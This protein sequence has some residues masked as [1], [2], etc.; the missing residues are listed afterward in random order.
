MNV[1]QIKN[2]TVSPQEIIPLLDHSRLLPHFLKE[3]ILDRA[4]TY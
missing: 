3:L 1:I 2:Y 4:R